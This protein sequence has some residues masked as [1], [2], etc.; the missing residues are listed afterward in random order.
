MND[1]LSPEVLGKIESFDGVVEPDTPPDDDNLPALSPHTLD[2]VEKKSLL[3]EEKSFEHIQRVGKMFSTS[4]MVPDHFKNN[5]GNC[6]IALN[7]AD[8]SGIDPFMCMQKMYVI[9][10][11]PAIESQLAIALANRSGRFTPIQYKFN[12]NKDTCIAFAETKDTG[13]LCEGPPVSLQMAKDEGWSSKQGSK[14]KTLPDL[15]LRYRAAMFF[16]RTYCPEATLG[17]YTREEATDIVDLKR[18][19]TGTYAPVIQPDKDA[20]KKTAKKKT[21]KKETEDDLTDEDRS[22]IEG[23]QEQNIEAYQEVFKELG[24]PKT[25]E[26]LEKFIVRWQE[27]TAE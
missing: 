4:T 10:G 9:K 18:T 6:V 25:S 2:T 13:E 19:S 7:F 3:F 8:R 5:L 15:M 23:M 11:K 21:A 27:I 20:P 26:D 22:S 14:W 1:A 24:W 17:F 12:D 16:I